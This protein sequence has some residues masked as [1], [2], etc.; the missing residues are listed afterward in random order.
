MKNQTKFWG[1]RWW[2]FLAVVLTSTPLKA[3]E[4][5]NIKKEIQELKETQ[6]YLLKEHHEGKGKVQTFLSEKLRF[7]G[8]FEQ[9]IV[10]IWGKST[11]TQFSAIDTWLALNIGADINNRARFRS[12]TTL[13]QIGGLVNEHHNPL[14]GSFLVPTTREFGHE[15]SVPFVVNAN[16]DY[17]FHPAFE[18]QVGKGYMPFGIAPQ[19][20][21]RT[22]FIKRNGPQYNRYQSTDTAP[23]VTLNGWQGIHF[24]GIF[25]VGEGKLGYDLY[26]STTWSDP[27]QIGGGSRLWWSLP[28][29]LATIG[30]SQNLGRRV[31]FDTFATAGVGYYHSLGGDIEFQV[32]RFGFIGEYAR[33]LANGDDPWTFYVQPHVEFF[34]GE[35]IL[36]ADVDYLDNPVGTTIANGTF[37]VA[38]DP[39]KKW[40]Y[41]G[42][43]NWLPFNFLRTRASFTVHNYTGATASPAG[44]NRDYYSIDLSAG[45]SF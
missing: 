9:G 23:I 2:F 22:L 29:S 20:T 6:E 41:T 5:E 1:L 7:G 3:G 21:E 43:I 4:I 42:G 15:V 45:V 38:A 32:G 25:P 36:F 8:F 18:I 12:Q 31:A 28:D 37:S 35:V 39:Y 11:D 40:E 26:T 19:T 33:S 10:G 34:K 16:F 24:L 13:L 30:I 27:G 44:Q 17:E 14:H